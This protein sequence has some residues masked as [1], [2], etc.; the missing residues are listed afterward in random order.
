MAFLWLAKKPIQAIDTA[1]GEAYRVI[2]LLPLMTTA[3]FWGWFDWHIIDGVV[4]N[5]AR[6]VRTTGRYVSTFLQR[7]RIQHTL[8]FTITFAAVVLFTVALF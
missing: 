2:G 5:V 6:S 4:D 3:K 8:C 1:W 7:G